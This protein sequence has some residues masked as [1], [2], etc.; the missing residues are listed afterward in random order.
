MK[1][2]FS[3]LGFLTILPVPRGSFRAGGKPVLYFPLVG[4]LIGCLLWV[5]DAVGARWAPAEVRATCDVLFLAAISGALHLDGLADSADGL[6]SHRSR[7]EVLQI[8]KDPRVGVMGVLA[9]LFCLGLKWTALLK[10]ANREIWLLAAPALARSAQGIALV[11]M[12]YAGEP[13]SL[14]K[15]WFQKNNYFLL[16]GIVVPLALPFY[17][18]ITTGLATVAGFLVFTAVLLCYFR[19]RLGG[20]TG[21]TVGALS[22]CVEAS[23]LVLGACVSFTKLSFE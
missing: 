4:L 22:E 14:S 16:L 10:L 1:D 6:F 18:D 23:V 20:V 3:A 21:D 17:L 12:D 19:R 7:Q 8:M 9:V 2:F 15:P 11:C 5:V 13:N